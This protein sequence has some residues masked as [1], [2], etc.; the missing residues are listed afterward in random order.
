MYDAALNTT[1]DR[2]L[3]LEHI[4]LPTYFRHLFET[5]LMLHQ[6]PPPRPLWQFNLK[7][8]F[9]GD[10]KQCNISHLHGQL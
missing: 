7:V 9:L 3:S 4:K 2:L 6:A 5:N 8:K 10:Y 1:E